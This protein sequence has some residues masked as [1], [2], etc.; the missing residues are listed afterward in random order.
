MAWTDTCKLQACSQ[1]DHVKQQHAVSAR[2]AIRVVAK[3]SGIPPKT[4]ETWYYPGKAPESSGTS[5]KPRPT[6]EQLWTSV[7]RRLKKIADDIIKNGHWPLE[8]TEKARE[9]VLDAN[10]ALQVLIFNIDP[11]KEAAPHESHTV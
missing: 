10:G 4:I 2:Q 3:E 7:A 11:K 5:P 6:Q 1:V 8:I 9:A